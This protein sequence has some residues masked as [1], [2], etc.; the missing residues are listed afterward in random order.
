MAY[1]IR[2][3]TIAISTTES[4]EVDFENIKFFA[5]QM[6]AGMDGTALTFKASAEAGGAKVAVVDNAGAAISLTISSSA[7]IVTLSGS[8]LASISGLRYVTLNS[9]TTETAARSIKVLCQD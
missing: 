9:G 5:L 8:Q 7:E 6:P 1:Y 4:D 2:T 3:A